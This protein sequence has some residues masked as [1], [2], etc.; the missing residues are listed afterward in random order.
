MISK[1]RKEVIVAMKDDGQEWDSI[2]I[3]VGHTKKAV[4]GHYYRYKLI[5]GLPPPVILKK[6]IVTAHIGLNI[7]RLIIDNPS[8]AVREIAAKLENGPSKSTVH[9][10]MV[11]HGFNNKRKTRRIVI[12]VT[13]QRKRLAFAK[14]NVNEDMDFFGNIFWSDEVYVQA[15]PNHRIETYW[16]RKDDELGY[17]AIQT[18]KQQGGCSVMFWGLFSFWGWGP[19]VAIE[20]YIDAREYIQLLRDYLL[21]EIQEYLEAGFEDMVFMQDN[22]QAHTS[23]ITIGFLERND[24][25]YLEWP[26]QS[27][28][29]NPIE[30]VWAKLKSNLYKLEDRPRNKT[31]ITRE[32]FNLWENLED[33]Y[34][35]ILT[36][37][38]PERL[39]KVIKN[40]GN[41][42]K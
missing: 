14:N 1:D 40:K 30:L 35:Q 7:K 22:A 36:E 2:C 3:A 26:P 19:L 5:A 37:A 6:P 33:D 16:G 23:P 42:I 17:K 39:E 9:R 15:Y 20:G 8:M 38:V 18:K 29:L 25:D 10:Y 32:F 21:P 28:D 4:Q 41:V 31:N 27:P 11:V 34:R 24:V 13:N 12:S